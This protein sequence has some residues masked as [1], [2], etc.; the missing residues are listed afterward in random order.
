MAATVTRAVTR[1]D[2]NLPS[3]VLDAPGSTR[4]IER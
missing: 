3:S 2:L 4:E 1:R